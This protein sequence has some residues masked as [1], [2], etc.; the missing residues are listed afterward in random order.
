MQHRSSFHTQP[1]QCHQR[2]GASMCPWV[3]FTLTHM[4][5]HARTCALFAMRRHGIPSGP[6]PHFTLGLAHLSRSRLG[7]SRLGRSRMGRSHLGRSHLGRS[8]S[9]HAGVAL[10]WPV[11]TI[12]AAVANTVVLCGAH[13]AAWPVFALLSAAP[14][15]AVRTRPECA[16]GV[17]CSLRDRRV[18]R[19]SAP[20]FVVCCG[21]SVAWMRARC[22]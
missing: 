11:G 7:R 17:W 19:A 10:F 8:H 5:S 22:R 20:C 21:L 16:H 13:P 4:H 1:R 18:S 15:L 6:V 12:L 14:A 9:G 2:Q 3:R